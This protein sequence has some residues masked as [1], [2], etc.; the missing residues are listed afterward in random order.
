MNAT[1]GWR[2]VGFDDSVYAAGDDAL[3]GFTAYYENHDGEWQGETTFYVERTQ[4]TN[5]PE[6]RTAFVVK[7]VDHTFKVGPDGEA[8]DDEFDYEGGSALYYDTAQEALKVAERLARSDDSAAY[9][10]GVNEEVS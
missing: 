4:T 5:Q 1:N 8:E 7:C 9:M 6:V 10:V 2:Q 3:S